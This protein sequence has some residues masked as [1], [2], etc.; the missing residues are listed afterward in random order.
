MEVSL[1]AMD[2]AALDGDR[3]VAITGSRAGVDFGATQTITITDDERPNTPATGQPVITGTAEV[4]ETLA[5]GQGDI[6]D[7]DGLPAI[8]P[9]DY[10]FQWVRVDADGVSNPEDI[11][12]ATGETYDPDAGDIGKKLQVRV[13]FTDDAGYGET[14]TSEATAAVRVPVSIEAEYETLGAG[15]E[16]LVLTLR[17]EGATTDELDVTV[18]LS[19]ERAWL[20]TAELSHE[21]TFGAGNPT[22]RA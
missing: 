2:N 15:I 5:A 3:T 14:L 22:P 18:T 20:D 17:R 12:T 13:S 21:V 4:G 7:D 6:D 11:A 10:S 19:Q 16:D 1:T 8:F 9:D